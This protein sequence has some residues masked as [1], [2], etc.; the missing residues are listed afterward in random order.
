MSVKNYCHPFDLSSRLPDVV[1]EEALQSGQISLLSCDSC[2]EL[3]TI[4]VLRQITHLLEAE[5]EQG[6]ST[7]IR[8]CIPSLGSPDWGSLTLNDL[9]YFLYSLRRLLRK[10]KSVCGSIALPP[11]ISAD[12]SGWVQRLGW[13][14]DAA[15]TV[16]AFPADPSLMTI[17]PSHQG[18]V[19]VHTLPSPQMLLP[20]SDRFST[21]RGLS[22]ISSSGGTGENNLA[23]KCTRK[24]MFFE[25]LHLDLQ[26]GVSERRTMPADYT[27]EAAPSPRYR[28]NQ[29]LHPKHVDSSQILLAPVSVQLEGVE[30]PRTKNKKVKKKVAFHSDRLDL[31]DF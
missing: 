15:L 12:S 26:G 3:I 11:Q 31:Y 22:T 27:L 6:N 29:H 19:H 2:E 4:H 21:L 28:D 30:F 20:P 23:F 10:H 24:R 7:P 8:I 9:T 1:V 16:A 17:F 18:L 14:S 25:T 13:L 5:E